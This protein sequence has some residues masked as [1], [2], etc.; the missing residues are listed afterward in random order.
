VGP[1][2][3][4]YISSMKWPRDIA[5]LSWVELLALVAEQQQQITQLQGQ[6]TKAAVTIESLQVEV[7]RLTREKKRQAAP[8]SKGTRVSKPKHLCVV[9]ALANLFR[10]APNQTAP[11]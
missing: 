10:T 5:S 9:E 3:V 8:F 2:E 11:A 7:E 1:V 6:L 4:V